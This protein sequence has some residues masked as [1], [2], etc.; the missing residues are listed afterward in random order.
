MVDA[1]VGRWRTETTLS[2]R[3]IAHRVC[4]GASKSATLCAQTHIDSA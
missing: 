3:G 2:I 1:L 4:L